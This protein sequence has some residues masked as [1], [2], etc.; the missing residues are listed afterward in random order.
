MGRECKIC[1]RGMGMSMIDS[2]RN[3]QIEQ[4]V[5][6]AKQ[7]G[8]TISYTVL[9][10]M[11]NSEYLLPGDRTVDEESINKVIYQLSVNGIRVEPI[12]DDEGY[13]TENSDSDKFVPAMINISQQ[14]LNVYN[15][16]ERL[17][18]DEL[19]LQPAFQRHGGIWDYVRQS[20]L[21]ESLMLR[22]PIPTF[23]FDASD[24]ERW[25]VIDGLQRLTA[26][27]NYL[28]GK[29]KEGSSVRTK[30]KLEGLQYLKEFEGKTFDELPRQYVRRIKE[31]PIISFCVENGTPDSVVY[32][33][34][35]RINTGGLHLEDQEIRNAMNHG[36]VTELAGKLAQG[37]EFLEATQYAVKTERM[38]D[39]EYVIRFF[40]FT[41]LD[42]VKEYEDDIDAFLIKTMKKINTYEK[43]DLERLERDFNRVMIYCRDIFGKYAFRK[44]SLD[45]RKGPIN[46]AIFELWAI[47][48]SA[49]SDEALN[50]IVEK[51]DAFMKKYVEL[52]NN[53]DFLL[54]LSSRK[55]TACIR[56]VNLT[57]TML[58]EFV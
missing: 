24:E 20:R 12:E 16:M 45:G 38:L 47:C 18:N 4:I 34:F 56:R 39:Q 17:E 42:Y 40:A 11:L 25:R 28:V 23:Y 14:M 58:E 2:K 26:F 6:L 36:K 3:K 51:K 15:L 52:L 49:L 31:A 57:R 32:N 13:E 55:K 53:K 44:I 1:G 41:E 29:K 35:Q 7:N 50:G 30:R 22:I 10:D 43:K 46:K 27:S 54:A 48:F 33:I 5:H 19:D 37:E 21:I 9:M 8:D